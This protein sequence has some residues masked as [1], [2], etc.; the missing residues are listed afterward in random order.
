MYI[1][2]Y[3]YINKNGIDENNRNLNKKP[4]TRWLRRTGSSITLQQGPGALVPGRG[5]AGG[6]NTRVQGALRRGDPGCKEVLV[7]N[8]CLEKPVLERER[9]AGYRGRK[10]E[11]GV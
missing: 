4:I 11:V 3:I 7:T 5:R 8:R 10:L 6:G 2:I 1:Y 9:A